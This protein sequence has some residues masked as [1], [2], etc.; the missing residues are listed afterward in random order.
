MILLYILQE[1][2]VNDLSQS[3]QP[4]LVKAFED[5]RILPHTIYLFVP[6]ACMIL[7]WAT[8]MATVA[9][10]AISLCSIME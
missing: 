6:L 2:S 7:F 9:R 10:L 5:A 1:L 4:G 8:L 3:A